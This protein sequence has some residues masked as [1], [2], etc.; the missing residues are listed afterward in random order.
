ML[1]LE[2]NWYLGDTNWYLT[3]FTLFSQMA[4]TRAT[5]TPTPT[6]ARQETT[7]PATGLWLEGEQRQGAMVEVA[8]GRSQ[9][10]EDKHLAQLVLGR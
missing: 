7:E 9:E 10:E 6:P 1:L 5:T 2:S 3:I 8:G 4:R